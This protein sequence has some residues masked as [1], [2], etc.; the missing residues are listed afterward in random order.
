MMESSRLDTPGFV[1]KELKEASTENRTGTTETN[2]TNSKSISS[3]ARPNSRLRFKR[4]NI[5]KRLKK[6]ENLDIIQNLTDKKLYINKQ[7]TIQTPSLILNPNICKSDLN[8]FL[9]FEI[10]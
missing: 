1:S 2:D 9:N 3:Y 4:I 7:K 5:T 6:L 10:K 8:N